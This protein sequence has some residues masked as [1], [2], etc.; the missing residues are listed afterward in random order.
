MCR[1]TSGAG[2]KI[3]APRM[4]QCSSRNRR[5]ESF[6]PTNYR[7]QRGSPSSFHHLNLRSAGRRERRA[8]SGAGHPLWRMASRRGSRESPFQT[9]SLFVIWSM[10][11][12]ARGWVIDN[13]GHWNQAPRI[14][15]ALAVVAAATSRECGLS[16]RPES[17]IGGGNSARRK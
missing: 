12:I 14:W 6:S 11:D 13:P 1:Q 5:K 17:R 8:S 4:S 15:G 2:A 16:S 3:E 9:G 10:E 7:N